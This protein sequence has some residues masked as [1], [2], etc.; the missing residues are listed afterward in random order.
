MQG[1]F[2]VFE[3]GENNI[4][5]GSGITKIEVEGRGRHI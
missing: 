2:P 3:V 5:H 4:T 1:D